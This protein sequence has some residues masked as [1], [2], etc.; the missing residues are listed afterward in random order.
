MSEHTA[1][2]ALDTMLITGMDDEAFGWEMLGLI[3]ACEFEYERWC[4]VMGVEPDDPVSE[5]AFERVHADWAKTWLA[6]GVMFHVKL[7]PIIEKWARLL[8]V[9]VVL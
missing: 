8:D 5:S 9:K 3:E 4:R 6:E 1:A 2:V 7:N